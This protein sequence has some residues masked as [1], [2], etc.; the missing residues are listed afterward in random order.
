[1]SV[2]TQLSDRDFALIRQ[3]VGDRIGI[4]LT[5]AKR[6]MVVSRLSRHLRRLGL[7]S[8]SSYCKLLSEGDDTELGLLC[9]ALTTNVTSFF[10][11]NHHFEFLA[12]EVLPKL[13]AA[14]PSQKPILIWSAG[15]STGEEPYSI[16]MTCLETLGTRRPVRILATDVDTDVVATAQQGV[17]G[18]DRVA[19]IAPERLARFFRRGTGSNL[20]RVRVAAEVRQLVTFRPLNLMGWWPLRSRFDFMF[21]RNVVIYFDKPTQRTL[22]ERYAEQLAPNAHLFIGHSES[23]HN[24]TDRFEAVGQTI[25]RKTR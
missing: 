13:D 4:V 23:L 3:I 20:G 19:G 21:C 2:A 6:E 10:R 9:N 14:L 1:M 15:C 22:F 7:A 25:Y 24:V 8:F 16:A 18:A 17:Y 12:A 11:E 5:E